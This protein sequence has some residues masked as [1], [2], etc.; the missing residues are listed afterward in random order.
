LSGTSGTL[1]T[2]GPALD[3]H[4]GEVLGELVARDEAQITAPRAG[5]V[6]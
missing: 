5:R 2:P 4:G 1:R 6:A 3:E